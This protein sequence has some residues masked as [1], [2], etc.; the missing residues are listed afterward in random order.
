LGTG[1]ATFGRA[2]VGLQTWRAHLF[3]GVRVIPQA[4]RV[5]TGATVLV[6]L[7]WSQLAI[8]VPCRVVGVIDEAARWGFAYG[9]LPGHLEQGEEAFVVSIAE[10]GSVAFEISSFSRPADRL[11]RLSGP[12]GRILQRAGSHGYLRALRR[13][14]DQST[15]PHS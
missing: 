3:H 11:L 15:S 4:T 12:F 14:V 13:Y 9:S 7:G 8:V 2:V 10:D 6:A 1:V 5:E